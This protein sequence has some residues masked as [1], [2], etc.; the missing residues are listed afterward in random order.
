MISGPWIALRNPKARLRLAS[1][2]PLLHY[3]VNLLQVKQVAGNR[4]RFHPFGVELNPSTAKPV[5]QNQ[6]GTQR[7]MEAPRLFRLKVME[8][9]AFS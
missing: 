1:I 3:G 9:P 6:F 4:G 8:C 7:L 2:T 5:F